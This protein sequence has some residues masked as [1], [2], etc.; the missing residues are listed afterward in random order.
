MAVQSAAA[1][2]GL[3]FIF[4]LTNGQLLP[5]HQFGQTNG[6]RVI[7]TFKNIPFGMPQIWRGNALAPV[8]NKVTQVSAQTL[9]Y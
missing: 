7:F 6:N 9:P 5:G 3:L 8:T 4:S 1:Q 2:T